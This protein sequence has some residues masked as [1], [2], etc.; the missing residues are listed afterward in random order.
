MSIVIYRTNGVS[1]LINRK[2]PHTV[3]K[4][5]ILDVQK[6]YYFCNLF[7][8]GS[9]LKRR[10][11]TSGKCL[12]EINILRKG[13]RVSSMLSNRD[14][15]STPIILGFDTSTNKLLCFHHSLIRIWLWIERKNG[16][17][18]NRWE[19]LWRFL[20]IVEIEG[21]KHFRRMSLISYDSTLTTLPLLF[22]D[23]ALESR[24]WLSG[25]V[26]TCTIK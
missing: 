18:G 13:S 8:L 21:V 26:E 20:R 23:V 9:S 4:Q 2:G 24:R 19:P 3:F 11:T 22:L 16:M 1:C 5:L 17:T 14:K 15:K 6:F 7:Y 10:A 12:I 25:S